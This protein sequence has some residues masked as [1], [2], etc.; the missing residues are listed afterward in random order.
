MQLYLVI[1]VNVTTISTHNRHQL[2]KI[3]NKVLPSFATRALLAKH[4]EVTSFYGL[5]TGSEVYRT[6]QVCHTRDLPHDLTYRVHPQ[7]NNI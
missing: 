1:I 4:Q 2:G 6:Q 5:Y 3:E 7:V